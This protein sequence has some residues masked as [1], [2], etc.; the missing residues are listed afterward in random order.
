MSYRRSLRGVAIAAALV[1]GLVTPVVLSTTASA[2]P[3][4]GITWG[5]L[6]KS[7]PLTTVGSLTGVR[8]GQHACY[9]RLVLDFTGHDSGFRVRYVN[10]VFTEGSG[11]VVPLRGGAKL[12]IV[13]LSP[14][15]LAPAHPAELVNATGYRTFRQAAWAGSFEGQTTIGLGVRAR[16]PFQAFLLQGPGNTSRLVI[17]VAHQW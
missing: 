4:C 14:S 15:R 5:S 7:A 9:D 12:E 16:L 10:A 3:Y 2:A 6:D 11:A 8:A 13:A 17:D 1:M